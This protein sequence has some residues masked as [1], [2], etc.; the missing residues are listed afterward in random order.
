MTNERKAGML[1]RLGARLRSRRARRTAIGVVIAVVLYGLIGF[2]A[3]P[4]L[5]RHFAEQQLGETLARP[6]TIRHVAL[7]PYTLRL[8][9]DGVRVVGP[10]V[11][12]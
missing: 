5:I 8:V 3:A 6:T 7:N 10:G 12:C 4:P 9:A 2:F 11:A 1:T